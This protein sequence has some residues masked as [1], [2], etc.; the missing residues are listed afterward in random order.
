M[1]REEPETRRTPKGEAIG[2]RVIWT[3]LTRSDI[4]WRFIS[5]V[6]SP[7]LST[8]CKMVSINALDEIENSIQTN[9]LSELLCIWYKWVIIILHSKFIISWNSD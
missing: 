5:S 7:R 6:L 2:C 3:A 9:Q 1:I 4:V 8:V